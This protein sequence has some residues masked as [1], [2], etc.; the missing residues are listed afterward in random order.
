MLQSYQES[1][2]AMPPTKS[3]SF[4][5]PDQHSTTW[6]IRAKR[7]NSQLKVGLGWVFP[8]ACSCI[9][10]LNSLR[11]CH[12]PPVEPCN[13]FYFEKKQVLNG[14]KNKKKKKKSSTLQPR[15]Y[16]EVLLTVFMVDSLCQGQTD[17]LGLAKRTLSVTDMLYIYSQK[18]Y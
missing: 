2:P 18:G 12:S 8:R 9:F 13:L 7:L 15:F 3:V 17:T 4:H 14:K 16:I 6:R 1:R 5:L 11:Y 10:S